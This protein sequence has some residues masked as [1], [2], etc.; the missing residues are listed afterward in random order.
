MTD[1]FRAAQ[2]PSNEAIAD[3]SHGPRGVPARVNTAAPV[4]HGAI[5]LSLHEASGTLRKF[6]ITVEG[7]RFLRD[8]LA[9]VIGAHD[10]GLSYTDWHKLQDGILA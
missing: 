1:T 10:A 4:F 6:L 3:M 5:S 7:A 8:V 9:D 2:W